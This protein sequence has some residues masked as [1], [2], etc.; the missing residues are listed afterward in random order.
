MGQEATLATVI[1]VT[2]PD[3]VIVRT[4]LPQMQTHATV[5]LALFGVDCKP[6]SQQEIVDWVE[7]HADAGRLS[8]ITVEWLRDS[9]GRVVGDLA[10][11][12]SG[13]TLT[14]WL[15]G[16]RAA[17]H[18]PGHFEEIISDGCGAPEPEC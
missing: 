17:T 3:T 16:R 11:P 5:H 4:P 10:D 12:Q 7:I 13:E 8:M 18:R 9:Y 2:R 15:L 14:S 1:R 6:E